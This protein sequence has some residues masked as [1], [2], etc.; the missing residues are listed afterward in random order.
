MR[1]LVLSRYLFFFSAFNFHISFHL[2]LCESAEWHSFG[3]CHRTGRLCN[4]FQSEEGWDHTR[5]GQQNLSW[6][7]GCHRSQEEGEYF[8]IYL[9]VQINQQMIWNPLWSN[10]LSCAV[11]C[12]QNLSCTRLKKFVSLNN[13]S[14]WFVPPDQSADQRRSICKWRKQES[15]T[16]R[17]WVTIL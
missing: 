7:T 3:T 5:F 2:S 9:F 1:V 12:D 13:F 6:A 16:E 14:S 17:I 10:I 4:R 8:P 15:A 11:L